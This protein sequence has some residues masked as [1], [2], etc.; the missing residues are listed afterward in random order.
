VTA[1]TSRIVAPFAADGS[2]H[3]GRRTFRFRP[4]LYA[5]HDAA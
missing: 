5:S 2:S 1:C 4:E 3:S